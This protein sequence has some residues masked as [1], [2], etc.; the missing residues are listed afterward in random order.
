M[1][2]CK[3]NSFPFQVFVRRILQVSTELQDARDV[4]QDLCRP[5]TLTPRQFE[6]VFSSN[7]SGSEEDGDGD[8]GDGDGSDPLSGDP[9][10]DP[11]VRF[12]GLDWQQLFGRCLSLSLNLRILGQQVSTP[13]VEVDLMLLSG[14]RRDLARVEVDVASHGEAVMHGRLSKSQ[15]MLILR[16][17]SR[18]SSLTPAAPPPKTKVPK[19]RSFRDS[20]RHRQAARYRKTRTTD[21]NKLSAHLDPTAGGAFGGRRSQE[22]IRGEWRE[23]MDQTRMQEEKAAAASPCPSRKSSSFMQNVSSLFK[24]IR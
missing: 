5:P 15:Q 11:S 9:Y 17:Q 6:L 10:L 2:D 1:P 23:V 7:G 8:G 14:I 24:N 22:E 13:G 3:E 12:F 4:L 20:S 18:V 19:S 16:E 21:L